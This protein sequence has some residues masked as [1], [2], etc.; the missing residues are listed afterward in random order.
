MEILAVVAD[1]KKTVLNGSQR[2]LGSYGGCTV[3]LHKAVHR[4]PSGFAG[5]GAAGETWRPKEAPAAPWRP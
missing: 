2:A 5:T 4:H 3:W 1:L